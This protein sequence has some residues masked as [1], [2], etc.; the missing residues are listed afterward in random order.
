MSARVPSGLGVTQFISTGDGHHMVL[1][2]SSPNQ[3]NVVYN[4]PQPQAPVI[5]QSGKYE[6]ILV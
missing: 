5:L 2:S 1:F 4:V 6:T 3:P